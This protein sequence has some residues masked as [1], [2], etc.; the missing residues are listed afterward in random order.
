MRFGIGKGRYKQSHL[1]D[2][3]RLNSR[4]DPRSRNRH[5]N[6]AQQRQAGVGT[7]EEC[8]PPEGIPCAIRGL[9]PTNLLDPPL[10]SDIC[11]AT[12]PCQQR[13]KSDGSDIGV[14]DGPGVGLATGKEGRE[15]AVLS[16]I[17]CQVLIGGFGNRQIRC[18]QHEN[19]E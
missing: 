18:A 4:E 2:V 16:L 8:V 13:E 10:D 3:G 14:R 15:S 5:P 1:E 17:L 11:A 19:C 9:L 7:V 12:I 6:F